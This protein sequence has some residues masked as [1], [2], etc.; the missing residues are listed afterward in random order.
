MTRRFLT[1]FAA[2]GLV[3][4]WGFLGRSAPDAAPAVAP[5][6]HDYGPAPQ[7]TGIDHWLNSEPRSMDELKGKVVVVDFWTYSCI[8]CLRTLPFMT[9]LH[10]NYASRGVVVIGVHTPEFGYERLTRNVE[11]ATQR[12]G[13]TYPVAQDNAYATWRAYDNQYW[14]SVYV[15]DRRG[16]IMLKHVGEGGDEDIRQAIETLLQQTVGEP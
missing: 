11:S 8:N 5:A 7:F 4:A 10:A 9:D 6:L 15:I 1:V 2:F 3:F 12:F 13:I 16:H 14:P